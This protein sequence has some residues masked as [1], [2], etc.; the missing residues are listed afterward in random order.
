[1]KN[2][3]KASVEKLF[4]Y[5]LPKELF[6][7]KGRILNRFAINKSLLWAIVFKLRL[8]TKLKFI[9]FIIY[10]KLKNINIFVIVEFD[11]KKNYFTIFENIGKIILTKINKI[12][13]L[14]VFGSKT[15]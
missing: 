2:S 1:M 7:T 15:Y 10:C 12:T 14:T 5:L 11:L 13:V 9:M 6:N 8:K 3:N 4:P